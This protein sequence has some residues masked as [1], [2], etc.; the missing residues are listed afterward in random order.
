M[1]YADAREQNPYEKQRPDD[2]LEEDGYDAETLTP[3]L[4]RDMIVK[5][6]LNKLYETHDH[7]LLNSNFSDVNLSDAHPGQAQ[8]FLLWQT[9]LDNVD[10]LLKVTH[11]STLQVRII[12]AASNVSNMDPTL[13]ALMFSIYCIALLSIDDEK[14]LSIF[15]DTRANM[16]ITFQL[17][18]QKAVVKCGALRSGNRESLTALFLYL[19][20]CQPRHC[21]FNSNFNRSQ[22]P[23]TRIHAQ[24]PLPS[25]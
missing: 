16:L 10:P 18:C 11:S 24:L 1:V 5:T 14:C 20:R 8:I 23:R 7:L 19:V 12:T 13:E 22:V 9:Y 2:G 4:D 6:S 15:Q 25:D 21:M 17:A 3:F